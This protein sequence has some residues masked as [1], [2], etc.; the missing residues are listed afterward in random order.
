MTKFEGT[1]E[2]ARG[3]GAFIAVP[4]AAVKALGGGGRIPVDATFDGVAYRGSVTSMGA[5]PCIGILKAIRA[6]IGKDVGDKV[7]VTLARDDTPR[8][9]SVP[10]DLAAAL[11]A[12]KARTK[13]DA[14]SFSHQREYVTWIEGAKR[15]DTR[16]RR[17]AE[18]VE[19][20]R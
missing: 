3:G 7:R 9:V 12:A 18:T 4:P 15:A 14:L 2:S 6:Q 1:I 8:S 19:R 10:S 11:K 20:L 13:F 17:V 16:Q 5:G